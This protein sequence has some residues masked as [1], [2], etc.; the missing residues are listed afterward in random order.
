MIKILR[1][2][3][4]L[5]GIFLLILAGILSWLWRGPAPNLLLIYNGDHI[6]GDKLAWVMVTGQR[7]DSQLLPVVPNISEKHFLASSPACRWIY[8]SAPD[9]P[10]NSPIESLYRVWWNGTRLHRIG[11][12]HHYSDL[13]L[14]PD[15]QWLAYYNEL[16]DLIL[17]RADGT[18][19][20]EV[21]LESNAFFDMPVIFS[22]DSRWLAFN[23]TDKNAGMSYIY[24][25]AVDDF[26][27]TRHAEYLTSIPSNSLSLGLW[28]PN[29]WLVGRLMGG[30]NESMSQLFRLRA[31][32]G[33][34][35][36]LMPMR[37][38]FVRWLPED[39]LLVARNGETG[40]LV[41]YRM[42]WT[43]AWERPV[44]LWPLLTTTPPYWTV[45]SGGAVR[46]ATRVAG[47]D[48]KAIPSPNDAAY[49]A[50]VWGESPDG[51]WLW[52]MFAY[53]SLRGEVWRLHRYEDRME[54]LW[55]TDSS[56]IK[57]HGWTADGVMW[58]NVHVDALTQQPISTLYT[59]QQ[60]GTGLTTLSE[61]AGHVL[62][63][64]TL[65]TQND[66]SP[67]AFWIGGLL[68]TSIGFLPPLFFK[69]K[70]PA[71]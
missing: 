14:S 32:S 64:M 40:N 44:A 53:Q 67:A 65:P 50:E 19:L 26:L 31:A 58:S 52:M 2:T 51:E 62:Q 30:R 27:P 5:L 7:A 47:G 3:S 41:A 34:W 20:G 70:R 46:A 69:R 59:M 9:K 18:V 71:P 56:L 38:A 48:V 22:P 61:Q 13:A 1:M 33:A 10:Y 45:N 68:L 36:P 21:S 4:G 28:L 43:V 57:F 29:D 35:E 54:Q 23:A 8:F 63:R 17:A 12:I 6:G 55:V 39:G 15:G 24:R 37:E 60:D 49:L 25:V 66:F 16:D 11:T 42:D